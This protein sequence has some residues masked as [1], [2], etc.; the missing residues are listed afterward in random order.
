MAKST[1]CLSSFS[2]RS[3]CCSNAFTCSSSDAG[4]VELALEEI[5]MRSP[6]PQSMGLPP[7]IVLHQLFNFGSLPTRQ[8][9]GSAQE[10]SILGKNLDEI[11]LVLRLRAYLTPPHELV[12]S[13][14]R[15]SAHTDITPSSAL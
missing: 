8:L 2:I 7:E 14:D 9:S 13:E 10:G 12:E 6:V 11:K 4:T 5:R 1:F 15:F 3:P